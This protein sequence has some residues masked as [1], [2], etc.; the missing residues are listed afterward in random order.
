[1]KAPLHNLPY[2]SL[3]PN[4]QH[5]RIQQIPFWNQEHSAQNPTV[6]PVLNV[7]EKSFV[8]GVEGEGEFSGGALFVEVGFEHGVGI[9][10]WF[11]GPAEAEIF[12][13][14]DQEGFVALGNVSG[15]F[16][17]FVVS[18]KGRWVENGCTVIRALC[19]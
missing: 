15:F 7:G 4:P 10:D 3:R 16:G 9:E 18:G 17:N 6:E 12:G 11:V 5:H 14:D 2:F 13:V 1:M 8:H 19:T